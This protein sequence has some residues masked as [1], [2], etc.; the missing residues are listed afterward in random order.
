MLVES[1]ANLDLQNPR[2][3]TALI[4]AI[5]NKDL[6]MLHFSFIVLQSQI[7]FLL[8]ASD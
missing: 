3:E 6:V 7:N 5:Q 2:G 4:I 8:I 1:G